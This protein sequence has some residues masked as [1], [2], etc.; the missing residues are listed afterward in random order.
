MSEIL[1]VVGNRLI[2][3]KRHVIREHR[4]YKIY[5][6][7]Y[8]NEIWEEINRQGKTVDVIIIVRD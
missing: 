8:Y 6:P 3:P 4:R 1:K 5:L 7:E 2:I